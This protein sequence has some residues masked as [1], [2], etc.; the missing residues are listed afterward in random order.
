MESVYTLLEGEGWHLYEYGGAPEHRTLLMGLNFKFG[1]GRNQINLNVPKELAEVILMG[2][3]AKRV[4]EEFD[5]AKK[6][7]REQIEMEGK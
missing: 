6:R 7:A 4:R 1:K 5:A 2:L 3:E